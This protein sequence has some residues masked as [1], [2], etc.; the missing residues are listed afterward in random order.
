[1]DILQIILLEEGEFNNHNYFFMKSGLECKNTFLTDENGD[2]FLTVDSLITSN[3]D[4]WLSKYNCNINAKLAGYNKM[5]MNVS[6]IE[7]ALNQLVDE[8]NDRKLTHRQFCKIFLN[9][10]YPFQ[11]GSGRTCKILFC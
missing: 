1:M 6:L 9:L 8:F 4:Y 3:N 2:L 11:D 10:I 5:Y 7:S